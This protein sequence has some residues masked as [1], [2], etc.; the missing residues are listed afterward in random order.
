MGTNQRIIIHPGVAEDIAAC[1]AIVYEAFARVHAEHNFPL[2]VLSV[3]DGR[4]G[5]HFAGVPGRGI[6]RRL[7]QAVIDTPRD[8]W[9]L[10]NGTRVIFPTVT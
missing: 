2:E 1:G 3:Q 4:A 9:C 6:G 8:H 10:D 5:A 7:M